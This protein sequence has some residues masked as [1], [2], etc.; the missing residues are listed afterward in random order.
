MKTRGKDASGKEEHRQRAKAV[1][2]SERKCGVSSTHLNVMLRYMGDFC[3]VLHFGRK[4]RHAHRNSLGERPPL[5]RVAHRRRRD[6]MRRQ[7][8]ELDRIDALEEQKCATCPFFHAL[9]PCVVGTSNPRCVLKR[10]DPGGG[11]AAE[12][13]LYRF[14]AVVIHCQKCNNERERQATGKRHHTE[15]VWC[16]ARLMISFFFAAVFLRSI[17]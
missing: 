8:A 10:F 1:W 12:Q 6:A 5:S 3:H 7:K 2:G 11:K 14:F 15:S 16:A 4:E 17:D 13:P 9:L